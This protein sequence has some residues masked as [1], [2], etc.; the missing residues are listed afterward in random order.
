[1][2][3]ITPLTFRPVV[4]TGTSDDSSSGIGG[5]YPF[6]IGQ[7]T[8]KEKGVILRWTSDDTIQ[9]DILRYEVHRSTNSNFDPSVQGD[10]LVESVKEFTEGEIIIYKDDG[11]GKLP[12]PQKDFTYYYEVIAVNADGLKAGS[13]KAIL[14]L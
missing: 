9:G 14:N 12:E 2:P 8:D 10:T 6:A 13:N 11:S 4:S 7:S 1:M 5:E 3:V